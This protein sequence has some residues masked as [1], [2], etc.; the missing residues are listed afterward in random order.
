ML[1]CMYLA[2]HELENVFIVI[3]IIDKYEVICCLTRDM[4]NP[5]VLVGIT[6]MR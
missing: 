5:V 3:D 2:H 1:S 4:L 6:G